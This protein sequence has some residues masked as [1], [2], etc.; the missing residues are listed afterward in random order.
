ME[1]SPEGLVDRSS[2]GILDGASDGLSD[3]MSDG[4]WDGKGRMV[5]LMESRKVDGKLVQKV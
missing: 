2:E 5:A 1:A 3:R 4:F